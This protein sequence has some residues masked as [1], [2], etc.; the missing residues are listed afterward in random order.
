MIRFFITVIVNMTRARI[1]KVFMVQT[2][3]IGLAF[4]SVKDVLDWDFED[5]VWVETPDK[6]KFNADPF[7]LSASSQKIEV[8]YEYFDYSKGKGDIR[9]LEMD[10]RANVKKLNIFLEGNKHISYPFIIESQGRYYLAPEQRLNRCVSLFEL[11]KDTKELL[12]ETVII[13]DVSV[14]DPTIIRY[15]DRWWLFAV[16][17]GFQL[18]IWYSSNLLAGWKSHLNNPVKID[19]EMAR[20]AG[21][22]FIVDDVLYRPVQNC[23][24]GYGSELV[25]TRVD[26]I[27]EGSFS[28]VVIKRI[29]PNKDG[30]YPDGIHHVSMRDGCLLVDGKK[31]KFVASLFVK[32]IKKKVIERFSSGV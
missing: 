3:G 1:F 23:G 19:V 25:I 7:V 12:N 10:C 5:V 32:K 16:V 6:S 20:P 13:D 29:L 2:W 28:E 15:K 17:D 30:P 4:K 11:A 27:S 18:Y 22:P 8:L 26:D 14:A 9:W 24:P 21:T 31:E